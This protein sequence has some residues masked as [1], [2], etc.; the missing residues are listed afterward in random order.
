MKFNK[1]FYPLYWTLHSIL[2][3]SSTLWF[4]HSTVKAYYESI[5]IFKHSENNTAIIQNIYVKFFNHDINLVSNSKCFFV[6]HLKWSSELTITWYVLTK[7]ILRIEVKVISLFELKISVIIKFYLSS[8]FWKGLLLRY[9]T[10]SYRVNL[11][12]E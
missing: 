9:Y 12:L 5:N 8:R 10:N 1:T 7:T 6:W 11:L 2:Q 4:L 3:T